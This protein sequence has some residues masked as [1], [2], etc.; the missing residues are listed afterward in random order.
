MLESMIKTYREICK[1]IFLF[2]S[3]FIISSCSSEEQG[4]MSTKDFDISQEDIAM[5]N[6]LDSIDVLNEK[7]P[8]TQTR[9]TFFSG[10]A[11]GLADAAGWAAGTGIGRWIGGAV[12]ALGG[13]AT[14]VLGTFV[15]G[16]AGPYVCTFL[17]SGAASFLCPVSS[18]RTISNSDAESQF[19]Y[20]VS[21][22]DSIGYY[23]NHM[24]AEIQKNRGKYYSSVSCVDYDLMYQ[25]IVTY[26]REIGKYDKALDDA[27]VKSCIVNQIKSICL[28]S[29]KYQS[30]PDSD[31]FLN[32]QCDYLKTKCLLQDSEVS[33][34]RDY[35]TKLYNKCSTINSDQIECYSKDLNTLIVNSDVSQTKKEELSLTADLTINSALYWNSNY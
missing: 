4:L 2:C 24:M 32:E 11:V 1:V 5:K 14:A 31:E 13:P 6:L 19:V 26:L 23:H 16:K 28:I 18:T 3:V 30:N 7:Y 27:V 10:G 35:T 29:E 20:I 34:Y 15:G 21:N 12:G 33:L 25:D 9:G 8:S 17:A 22:E